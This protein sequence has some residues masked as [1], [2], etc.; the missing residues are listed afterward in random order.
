MTIS[1]Q[2]ELPKNVTALLDDAANSTSPLYQYAWSPDVF[3]PPPVARTEA[4]GVID[5]QQQ[6]GV[7][8]NP[9]LTAEK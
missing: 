3:G 2:R 4:P 7:R 1:K 6:K 8:T 9:A 5:N